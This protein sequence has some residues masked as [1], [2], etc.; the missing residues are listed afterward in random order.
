MV[1]RFKQT[2]QSR[3]TDGQ[4]AHEMMLSITKE[5]QIRTTNEY[6]LIPIR[7]AITKKSTNNREG[8]E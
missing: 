5:M 3:Q 1:R 6:H 4:K 2:F 7:M 8:G